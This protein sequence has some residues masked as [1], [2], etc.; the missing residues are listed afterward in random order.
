MLPTITYAAEL[1]RQTIKGFMLQEVPFYNLSKAAADAL[2]V[3]RYALMGTTTQDIPR[4]VKRNPENYGGI[5]AVLDQLHNDGVV[6]K[7]GAAA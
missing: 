3:W 6:W 5:V 4:H 1:R 2:Q 7:K